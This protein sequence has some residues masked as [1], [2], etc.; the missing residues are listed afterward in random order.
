[1]SIYDLT[2]AGLDGSP[3]DLHQFK[4]QAVLVTDEVEVNG[5]NRHPLHG[6]R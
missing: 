5:A 1:M 6:Q 4:G 2:L 3:F